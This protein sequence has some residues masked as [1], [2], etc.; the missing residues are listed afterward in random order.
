M[1]GFGVGGR[2]DEV[3]SISPTVLCFVFLSRSA[4]L[5]AGHKISR[6]HACAGSLKTT[7]SRN[8]LYDV[9]RSWVKAH[10]VKVENISESSPA[11][12]LLEKEP[13]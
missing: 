12:K 3:Y 5:N 11:R 6:S 10:P 7:A 4:L 13:K 1:K 9:F 2:G 8:E